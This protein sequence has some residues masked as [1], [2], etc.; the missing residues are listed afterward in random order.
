MLY[1]YAYEIKGEGGLKDLYHLRMTLT[2]S[3]V[4]EENI[5]ENTVGFTFEQGAFC[6]LGSASSILRDFRVL[7]V[8]PVP[9][10]YTYGYTST[11]PFTM[12]FE[13]FCKLSMFS[14]C[15]LFYEIK[16]CSVIQQVVL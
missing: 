11:E 9:Y 16:H 5:P 7:I 8:L 15:I 1:T 10:H 12:A 13:S 4:L 3:L 6:E 2:Q 14:C